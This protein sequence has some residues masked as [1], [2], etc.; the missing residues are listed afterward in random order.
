MRLLVGR[1]FRPRIFFWRGN[2]EHAWLLSGAC[3][4]ILL[5]TLPAAQ[6]PW[7]M[8][9]WTNESH[10][11]A[12]VDALLQE[13]ANAALAGREGTII[14]MD[15]RT[16]RVRALVNRDRAYRQPLMPGSAMKPFTALAALRAGLIDENSRTACPGRFTGLSFSL[17]C[18]HAD[19]LPPFTPSQAIAYSC[20]YYFATLGERLGRDRLIETA[21]QFGLGQPTGISDQEVAGSMRPCET[22]NSARLVRGVEAN[23]VSEQADCNARE[24]VGESNNLQVTPIQ[25]LTAYTALING[26][27]LYQ[28]RVATPKDFQAIEP[29]QIPITNQQRAIITE[30]MAGA[31]RYGTARSARLDALPLQIL[32]KTGTAMPAKGFRTNGWFI[33]FAAPFQSNRELGPSQV[34]LAVLVLLSRA[35][36]S[37]A[38]MTAKPIFAAYATEVSRRNTETQSF[39]SSNVDAKGEKLASANRLNASLIKVH[40]VHDKLTE[41]LS[42]EDYVLGV[43]RAE[44]TM[45]T[46]P[47]ALKALA[48]AIRTYALKNAGRH[49]KDG[50]DFCS[51]THC[52][53]FVRSRG[54]ATDENQ[55]LPNSPG[56]DT[57][58][59]NA[60]RST[61]GQVLLDSRGQLID[62]YFGA[63]C[64]GHT[65]DV[66]TL[67]GTTPPEYLQGARDEYCL[68]GPH[69]HWNDVITRADLLRALQSD[70]R[71]DVGSRLDEVLIGKRDETG[72]AEFIRLEGEH[73][74]TVRGWDF[75]IIVGRVLGWNVLKSSRF[76]ISRSGSD[77][78]FRGSGFG[79]GLGLCQEGA[80]VLAARGGSY[81]KILEKYFPGTSVKPHGGNMSFAPPLKVENPGDEKNTNSDNG[82]KADVLNN[83]PRH[84]PVITGDWPSGEMFINPTSRM[85]SQVRPSA[86]LSVFK[87]DRYLHFTA[88][89]VTNSST[90]TTHEY[91]VPARLNRSPRLLTISSEHFRLTYPA[92]VNRRDADQVLTT[93][94]SARGDYLRR[95]SAALNPV[96]IPLLDIRFN[97]STGDFTSRTGQ[98]WWA[99][100]ATKG[101]RIELQ[102]LTLLKRRGALW[103]TLRHELAHAVIDAVSH[104]R[105]LRWLAEGLAIYLAGE[106]ESIS[107]YLS[108]TRL[109]A[110]ELE[111]R[112]ER[113]ASQQ[114]MRAL[115][116]E[117]YAMTIDL[118]K[119]Q[120]EAGVWKKLAAG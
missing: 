114:D 89:E 76:E 82:W 93:L 64:G 24:A 91:S 50:Y 7:P 20:N 120:G 72:R 98:P 84:G 8:L 80:H 53:R 40:L 22:G 12:K 102:P 17:P 112:L 79:H 1:P 31:V 99:A 110:D 73:R 36:G 77:F 87:L 16:G 83:S 108:K 95:A 35:H 113:P 39:S 14:I 25:L 47:E 105:A 66:G 55:A 23:H 117:A 96:D 54:I 41:E 32:G 70:S 21:R 19:H 116:A 45:E 74:K 5:F 37:E 48:I 60:V 65:A 107:H 49:A 119:R 13:A 103:T 75:K 4:A 52:Q 111:R 57:K 38:A 90:R 33:G 58:L 94:E 69:A 43:M 2:R 34:D 42:L 101:N 29:S 56:S 81:Q 104:H 3:F 85:I 86:M 9:A 11:T 26:G 71:T 30:G 109:K 6:S 28:A 51:T 92:D 27:H 118:I 78:I 97:E 15:A 106:S 67:W 62:A 18:V 68:S 115:Y 44:G 59:I 88:A 61:E 100:A 46:E 63:S 10:D